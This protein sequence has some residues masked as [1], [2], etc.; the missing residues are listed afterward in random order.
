MP[1]GVLHLV[2]CLNVGGTERQLYALLER[3]DRDRYT[4]FVGCFKAGGDLHPKLLDLGIEPMEFPLRGSLAQTNT[5]YQV[6]RLALAGKRLGIG[7]IHAHDFYSNLIG[8]AAA[9]LCGAASIASRRDLAHWLSPAKKYALSVACQLADAVLANAAAVAEQSMRELGVAARKLRVVPNGIDL[10]A[11]DRQAKAPPNPALPIC[12]GELRITQ[13]SSMHLP[14]KGHEDLLTAAAS[15]TARGLRAQYL[16]V[17]DGGLRPH[18]EARARALGVADRVHFLGRRSDVPSILARSHI[19]VHPSWAEGFP[20]AVLEAMC[21]GKPLVTTRVGGVPEVV[22]DGAE[23]LLV[24]PR[25]P[26][27]LATA[28]ATLLGNKD[29]RRDIGCRGRARVE[30]TYSLERMC[31]TVENIYA[32]LL[33]PRTPGRGSWQAHAAR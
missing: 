28:V 3:L 16:L 30:A 19:V 29:A 8:V 12:E 31:A 6:A 21:A 14:D 17:G 23:G 20:N 2:D 10:A 26:P 13:V 32:E 25:Q 22:R 15:L 18:L 24:P 7:V 33:A 5:A 11:F 27:E 1:D 4:P 9:R